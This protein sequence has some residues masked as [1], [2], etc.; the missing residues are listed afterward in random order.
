MVK[1]FFFI[2]ILSLSTFAQA[3]NYMTFG[4]GNYIHVQ[5]GSL[6]FNFD[7]Y[8]FDHRTWA[9]DGQKFTSQANVKMSLKTKHVSTS[10]WFEV[11]L[12]NSND[13][14][15]YAKYIKEPF[16]FQNRGHYQLVAIPVV[17]VAVG[18]L[19]GRQFAWNSFKRHLMLGTAVG[20]YGAFC[21]SLL[22]DD[23]SCS[24]SGYFQKTYTFKAYYK[25]DYWD[26]KTYFPVG[27]SSSE[28]ASYVKANAPATMQTSSTDVGTLKSCQLTALGNV[29]NCYYEVR[30]GFGRNYSF[31]YGSDAAS[32]TEQVDVSE[33]T[34]LTHFD[35]VA[36]AMPS[37]VIN[38]ATNG[39][40]IE[41]VQLSSA[42]LGN[43]TSVLSPPYTDPVTGHAQQDKIVID[44]SSSGIGVN[45][46]TNTSW[47]YSPTVGQSA[48]T[49]AATVETVARPDLTGDRVAAPVST[50]INN[51]TGTGSN[52][53][54]PPATTTPEIKVEIPE[55]TDIAEFCAANPNVL[56][57]QKV[58]KVEESPKVLIP[59]LN[60]NLSFNPVSIFA[61]NSTCPSPITVAFFTETLEFKYDTFC[62]IL[63]W[64]RG[65]IIAMFSLM[66]VRILFK[67]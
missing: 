49:N 60:Q 42:A 65:L 3:V 17:V 45:S 22:A 24:P 14:F 18:G 54:N 6:H 32:H 31:S 8:V 61:N 19:I 51:V 55:F 64:L 48:V 35:S 5:T 63:I 56:A 34:L 58:E 4:G 12:K 15:M 23:I 16:S 39:K 40:N 37:Q 43:R 11:V 52:V 66:A 38:G 7:K 46:A 30:P 25:A 47:E 33:D 36:Q 50:V 57:C 62:N 44:T 27:S 67:D 26:Q 20:A 29:L 10:Q 28:V 41:D 21:D 2:I 53:A 59:E 9:Y 1:A 13:G